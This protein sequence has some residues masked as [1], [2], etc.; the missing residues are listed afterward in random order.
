MDPFNPPQ[1]KPPRDDTPIH[2][3]LGLALA[4]AMAMMGVIVGCGVVL[5]VNYT[6]RQVFAPMH[7]ATG[8]PATGV[9]Q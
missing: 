5:A 4:F 6:V 2:A 3:V 1:P 7:A 8:I 9:E